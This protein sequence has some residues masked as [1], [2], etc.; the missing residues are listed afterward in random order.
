MPVGGRIGILGPGLIWFQIV[1]CRPWRKSSYAGSMA[2]MFAAAG[3]MTPSAAAVGSLVVSLLVGC[4]VGDSVALGASLTALLVSCKV[5]VV[6][7]K[8]SAQDSSPD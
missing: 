6:V 8:S 2:M 3:S 1:S 5:R 4:W 7:V